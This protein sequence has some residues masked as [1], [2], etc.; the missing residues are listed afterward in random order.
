MAYNKNKLCKTL[1]YLTN[2]MLIFN[3]SEKGPGLVS[4]PYFVY[5]FSRKMILLLHCI[6]W[7]NFI[8]W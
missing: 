7:P 2:D 1:D 3:F 5:D 6:N 8:I 4:P